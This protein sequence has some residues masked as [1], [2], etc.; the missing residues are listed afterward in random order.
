MVK[1]N[2]WLND[3]KYIRPLSPACRMCAKGSKLVLLV[4]GVCYSNCFYCPLSFEKFGKDRIFAD[5]W[6]LINEDDTKK[7][8]Q[9]AK[10][11]NAKGA[12]ITGGDP[13]IVWRRTKK[14]IS[15]LKEKF[16]SN[17]HI[18][19]Y[20]QALKNE[21]HIEDLISEGL[22]EIR[23]HPSHNYWDK[24]DKSPISQIICKTLEKD[25]DVAIEIPTIPEMKNE[26][27]SLIEWSDIHG[28]KW[29]NIN[30]LEF[31]ERNTKK[32]QSKKYIVKND[33]SSSVKKSEKTAY[34]IL[35][36]I[37][38][39][40][41]GIG[42]HYCSCSFK[43]GVQLKNRIIRR[44]KNTVKNHEIICDEGTTIKGVIY[45]NKNFT[46]KNIY[47]KLINEYKIEKYKI[48]INY[49]KNRI[50]TG[51]LELNKIASK[52]LSQGL[53]SFLIE[54]YP[55]ADGLEVEKIPLP[56]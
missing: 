23:F 9:E 27:I 13:L 55:T 17:F 29:I 16:G 6:E 45:Q 53:N 39:E 15:I 7:I 22:D 47:N 36:E 14:Y 2:N 18:H 41:Y 21:Y 33:I 48:F 43:D 34:D 44:A 10:Y 38:K 30:E 5:E 11:I 32:F 42:V 51:V 24:M 26:I 28:I 35:L 31:S 12:G 3:S 20:T 56:I 1:I 8:I 25:V 50:E 46:L 49:K 40:D 54:E 37:S 52:L 19:L 4:T